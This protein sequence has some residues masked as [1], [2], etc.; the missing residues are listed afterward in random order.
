MHGCVYAWMCACMCVCVHAC[1]Y[2]CMHVCM[3]ACMCVC[4]CSLHLDFKP[5]L[6]SEVNQ[7]NGAEISQAGAK[8]AQQEP[9][10]DGWPGK[11][12]LSFLNFFEFLKV[13]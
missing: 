1:V 6:K 4:L 5:S 12:N 13:F 8:S 3:C 9:Q 11:K 10:R 7:K 2:V